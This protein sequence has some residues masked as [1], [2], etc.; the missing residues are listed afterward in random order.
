M[1][2]TLIMSDV[3]GGE[4]ELSDGGA[5]PLDET[6]VTELE[7]DDEF[8]DALSSTSQVGKLNS[9]G[10][11]CTACISGVKEKEGG[12]DTGDHYH[13]AAV[14]HPTQPMV[15]TLIH[16]PDI[17]FSLTCRIKFVC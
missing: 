2:L 8:H 13:S 10:I 14:N 12:D 5:S 3:L 6:R 17:L 16:D 15:G 9:C 4:I 1:I 11:V 7:S